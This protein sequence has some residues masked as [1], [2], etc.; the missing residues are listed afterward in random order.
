[1]KRTLILLLLSVLF[2]SVATANADG[3]YWAKTW[4]D[5][6]KT[7]PCK[8]FRRNL[9]GSWTTAGEIVLGTGAMTIENSSAFGDTNIS[10][11]TTN[12]TVIDAMFEG[13]Q[14]CSILNQRCGQM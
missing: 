6:V 7:L 12:A 5:A 14:E 9:D 3:L 13:T 11:G 2:F 4:G 10:F 1:M 8:A